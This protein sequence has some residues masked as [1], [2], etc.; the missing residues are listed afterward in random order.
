MKLI[1]DIPDE[2]LES[3][4]YCQYFGVC[5]DKLIE[6][7]EGG[8]PYVEPKEGDSVSRSALKDI[9][10]INKGNFNTVE[11]IREW[12]DNAPPIGFAETAIKHIMGQVKD[13]DVRQLEQIIIETK[14]GGR[15]MFK[16]VF[17]PDARPKGEWIG[18]TEHDDT[19]KCSNCK[20][21][22]DTDRLKMVMCDGK[23]ELP[24]SCPNCGANMRGDKN[25]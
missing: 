2:V 11:G 22:F 3:K 18:D 16:Q 14:T 7:I 15:Y 21:L 6:T 12:I 4:Q 13:E 17:L 8:T 23:Y 9:T 19:C 10:Y 1:I 20:Q 24:P 25:E 5:S